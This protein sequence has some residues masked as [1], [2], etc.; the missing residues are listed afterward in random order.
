M[1]IALLYSASIICAAEK[2][3]ATGLTF[4]L[5][6]S[7]LADEAAPI[8][9]HHIKPD[10]QESLTKRTYQ[11]LFDTNACAKNIPW[12][13]VASLSL[14][15]GNFSAKYFDLTE[16]MKKHIDNKKV[17][18]PS[19]FKEVLQVSFEA[20]REIHPNGL[21]QGHPVH[22][23]PH[24]IYYAEKNNMKCK[25]PDS[26]PS[27]FSLLDKKTGEKIFFNDLICT[28]AIYFNDDYKDL[29]PLIYKYQSN[30]P[31]DHPDE[32]AKLSIGRK[33]E[34]R[35][36]EWYEQRLSF[37]ERTLDALPKEQQKLLIKEAD[38][39]FELGEWPLI[40]TALIED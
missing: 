5:R 25:C 34:P 14:Y 37:W 36:K 33:Q 10:D 21:H 19:T 6:T 31:F 2:K 29:V 18:H 39:H 13:V 26:T 1:T 8:I 11:E 16:V 20:L 3:E 12:L 4:Y 15:P 23:V 27:T 38:E 24:I 35:T 9:K 28:L 7:T 40:V 22:P 32:A 17:S 30:A